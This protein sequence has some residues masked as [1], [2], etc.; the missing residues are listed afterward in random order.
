MK[1]IIITLV[2]IPKTNIEKI[3]KFER[4]VILFNACTGMCFLIRRLGFDH[5]GSN[6]KR[7]P[8]FDHV[9]DSSLKSTQW[10]DHDN[11]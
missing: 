11:G 10:L 4:F 5:V 9:L 6:L 2:I 7:R 1:I 3:G 8:W